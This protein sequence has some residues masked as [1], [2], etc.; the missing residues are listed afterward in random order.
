MVNGFGKET[1]QNA[2]SVTVAQVA[3]V[4]GQR[5]HVSGMNLALLLSMSGIVP[6]GI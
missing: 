2:V 6:Q 1:T 3:P 4:N 5:H